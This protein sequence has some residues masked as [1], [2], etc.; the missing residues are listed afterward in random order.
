MG[1]CRLQ[2]L[3]QLLHLRLRAAV[4]HRDVVLLVAAAGLHRQVH[5]LV[6]DLLPAP[7]LGDGL[8]L[9]VG[10]E[11]DEGL[12]LEHGARHGRHLADAP[13]LLEVLQGI[14]RE[15]GGSALD[16][17]RHPL[18]REFPPGGAPPQILRQLQHGDADAQGA[19]HRVVHPDLQVLPLLRHEPHHVV[20]AR[21][22][23]REHDGDDPVIPLLSDVVKGR[24]DVLP[25][26]Q[27]GLGQLPP[28]QPGIDVGGMDVHAVPVLPVGAADAQRDH[29]D[30]VLFRRPGGQVGA[31]IGE[32][33]DLTWGHRDII[34]IC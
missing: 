17:L 25:R 22:P 14:H 18:F 32:Q 29:M 15:E 10:G 6:H 7:D 11:G 34:S 8:E 19:A 31:G 27:G 33:G 28:L 26:G 5:Q 2:L 9:A 3:P 23:P 16:E 1:Q 4:G 24:R 12:D 21:E 20:G 13:A 30:A